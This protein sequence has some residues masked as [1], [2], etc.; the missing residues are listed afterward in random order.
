[1]YSKSHK[2]VKKRYSY[3]RE[4][5]RTLS[6]NHVTGLA[7]TADSLLLVST[8]MGVN[9]HSAAGDDFERI[10][11]DNASI[12]GS[13]SSNFVNC[14]LVD[15]DVIW[16]GT[17]T[18]GVN[19]LIPQKLSVCR[20]VHSENNSGS[21]SKNPVN[22]IYE[23][24]HG[25]LWVG[26]VEG[27]L[28]RKAAGS[29]RF[30]HYTTEPPS[31]LSHNSVSAIT[32]DGEGRLWVGTWG[33]GV[34]LLDLH[35]PERAALKYITPQ[36]HSGFSASFIG[37]LYYDSINSGM[38]IGSN[39]GVFFY[40]SATGRLISPFANR[41]AEGIYGAIGAVAD[42]QARLWMGCMDGVYVVDLRS[43][44]GDTFQ[45]RYLKYKLDDP[46]S[47]LI[48][49]ICCFCLASDGALW[50]GS[51]GYGVYRLAPNEKGFDSF[52]SYTTQDG[53]INNNIRGMLEDDKGCLW[54]SAN[55]G[56]S[57]F[58]PSTGRFDNY[59]REDGLP[60]NQF[61]W[62]AYCR[63]RSGQLYF[64]GLDGLVAVN[65]SY[66]IPRN[67]PGKVALTKLS[68]AY[69]EI[70]PGN[71]YVDADIALAR[72]LR[73][74]ERD[75]SFS[76]EFSAL[77]YAPQAT[78]AYCYRL[79]GFDEQ[80]VETP[81]TRRFA[82]Y[83]NLPPG[84]YTFQVKYIP[85]K[86]AAESAPV[87]EL[88]VIVS[89]FFYKTGRFI[90]A[91][92]ALMSCGA[93]Y[94]YRRHIYT[95][96]KQKEVLHR[97]VE[98]RT[99]ELKQQ[100]LILENQT[101][102][103]E[104]QNSTLMQQNEK[105]TRQKNQLVSMSKKV[106]ELTEDKLSFFTN[107]THEFRTPITLIIGPIEKALKLSSNPQVIKQLNFVER[108]SKYL[109]SLVNQLLDFHKVESGNMEL[110]KTMNSFTG[111][112][113][114]LLIP[115]EAFAAE[116]N[117]RIRKFYRMASAEISFDRDAMQ[118]V[119]TNLLFNAI[120]F[121]P[122]GGTV[123]LYVAT[124][125]ERQTRKELLYVGVKDTGAGIAEE[126]IEKVFERFYQS[127]N[128]AE[129]SGYGQSGT[130][131]G[132]YLSKQITELHGGSIRAKNNRQSGCTFRITLPVLREG[133][134]GG[135]FP[136]VG[137]GVPAADAAGAP[138][139]F[140]PGKLAI[141]TVEDNK[142]MRSYI[143]SILCDHYNVLEAANGAEALA[144]LSVSS[145]DFIVCDLMMPV[146]D[147]MELLR[148][149][150]ENFL[151][152][153]IPFLML[154][155]KTGQQARIDSYRT[156]AD[157]YL[158]KPF[159]E[160]LLLARVTGILGNRRRLQQQFAGNMKVETLQMEEESGD[161]KFVNKALEVIRG[162]YKNS[163]Y[164]AADFVAAMGVSKSLLNKKMQH[165][166][167]QS[168][169]QFIRSYRLNVAHDLI[170]KNRATRSMNISEIAYEVGFNDPKYFTRCFTK[171][172][173]ISPSS[174]LGVSE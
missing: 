53:L 20:Y 161:K 149:V 43:R 139:H 145:V 103:L 153:H 113:D 57:C 48:E 62:N 9:L 146:M 3:A 101:K 45:Y 92:L 61:Y 104:D 143:C 95:L 31:R 173:N 33:G 35:R 4:N 133:S 69:K 111:L 130:G 134:A 169:N 132:L 24:A 120:K 98:E 93:I 155:A 27:G 115:F 68:V 105:I 137:A 131:I 138:P 89:P 63:S 1:R 97:T 30:T 142:D 174:L 5:P 60:G 83:T 151:I 144:V 66:S 102:A 114:S 36:T 126:D 15:G 67:A 56:L 6:Q 72:T 52:T 75:K 150:K 34:S 125:T 116:R 12:D 124:L 112:M 13:L 106:Q 37:S 80:W 158:L 148:K 44:S 94:F 21:L 154:T 42:R 118:K 16:L 18:G 162:N 109:L 96:K 127:K 147:G 11:Q 110:V 58:D 141:L 32:A 123:S 85:T 71:G 86:A 25:N 160:E 38:W 156:G 49:K 23:D 121:T 40:E 73:L 17:E 65:P 157:G 159:S 168:I 79:K 41:A 91:M 122:G 100:T 170:I 28:N 10:T 140:L 77:D 108:N 165:L 59:T 99:H 164:E 82:G 76:L 171:R 46:S 90:F 14:M 74:H 64:G 117:V 119:M 22:A 55:N 128:H 129:H 135:E 29:N 152:S 26:T 39:L 7:L 87:T 166:V 8:L 78:A 84:K 107:I 2:A 136:R 50:I 88:E 70:L 47:M 54:I 172:F 167:G 51:N 81:A 163:Y 19:K